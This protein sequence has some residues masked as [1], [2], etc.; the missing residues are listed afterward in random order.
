M[1]FNRGVPGAKV[2]KNNKLIV[3]LRYH[4][5]I[6]L[7]GLS[8]RSSTQSPPEQFIGDTVSTGQRIISYPVNFVA[9]EIGNFSIL[10]IQKIIKLK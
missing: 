1:K 4:C 2:F 5:F 7:I 10:E 3:V 8:I 6:A 9:G